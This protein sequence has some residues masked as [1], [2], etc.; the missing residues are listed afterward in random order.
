MNRYSET[1]KQ[2]ISKKEQAEQ[3][4]QELY[5]LVKLN[6]QKEKAK[7]KIQVLANEIGTNPNAPNEIRNNTYEIEQ[8]EQE[9]QKIEKKFNIKEKQDIDIRIK[10]LKKQIET[11]KQNIEKIKQKIEQ[12]IEKKKN[13]SEISKLEQEREKFLEAIKRLDEQ[14]ETKKQEQTTDIEELKKVLE[15]IKKTTTNEEKINIELSEQPEQEVE[16]PDIDIHIEE[17][18]EQNEKEENI[19]T[20]ENISETIE[21]KNEEKQEEQNTDLADTSNLSEL[22]AKPIKEDEQEKENNE[23][24][25]N[26]SE[27]VEEQGE[28]LLSGNEKYADLYKKLKLEKSYLDFY[29]GIGGTLVLNAEDLKKRTKEKINQIEK[30]MEKL[31]QEST[32]G[33]SQLPT[34]DTP[35]P[36]QNPDIVIPLKAPASP[37]EDLPSDTLESNTESELEEEKP[38]SKI[39]AD[40]LFS[41]IIVD[42]EG[43]N[44]YESEQNAQDETKENSESKE[45]TANNA[46]E[47][48]ARDSSELFDSPK[49]STEKNTTPKETQST[50]LGEKSGQSTYQKNVQSNMREIENQSQPSSLE[51]EG[52]TFQPK[53]VGPRPQTTTYEQSTTR[54]NTSQNEQHA[55]E[56]SIEEIKQ[57]I[58]SG[59]GN[60]YDSSVNIDDILDSAMTETTQ[61][62]KTGIFKK[63][64]RKVTEQEHLGKIRSAIRSLGQQTKEEQRGKKK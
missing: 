12:E 15:T 48:Y 43:P 41:A 44:N 25:E 6:T 52:D 29:E 19:K 55:G 9:I 21:E 61:S 31:Q 13:L 45:Q 59:N 32:E 38:E 53:I 8:I 63:I 39:N 11:A 58:E 2:Q 23:P 26:I 17:P 47:Q 18:K 4:I 1:Y 3:N 30:A 36:T 51:Q 57:I 27:N 22:D 50:G 42:V 5:R 64:K 35:L 24:T 49:P 28:S 40:E 7:T 14:I 46:D 33:L 60:S 10:D 20:T 16:T 62:E 56:L 37:H 34:T 54:Q